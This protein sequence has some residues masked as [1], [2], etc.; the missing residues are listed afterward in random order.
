VAIGGGSGL[1]SLLRGLKNYTPNITAVVAV[2]DNGQS[3]G[4]IRKE[5]NT[6]PPGD[7]RKC[8]CALS[9][10][11]DLLVEL[12]SYRFKKGK[13][14]NGH[15]L[16]NLL[17]VALNDLEGG[18]DK[19]VIGLS[20]ILKTVGKVL[21]VTLDKVNIIG[22]MKSGA[23]V[24]GEVQISQTGHVD[25]I[26][27]ISLSANA[28]IYPPVKEAIN[29]ADIII[30]GPGSLYTSIIPPL[31]VAGLSRA[32]K[33]CNAP[34]YYICNT[35]TERGETEGY[36]VDSHLKALLKVV[37]KV[38]YCIVNNLVV[39][40]PKTPE[41][42]IGS[43]NLLLTNERKIL[44]AKIISADIIDRQNPLCHNSELLAKAILDAYNNI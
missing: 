6:L 38:D 10:D 14:L 42:E 9:P 37:K 44:G 34:I 40:I 29:N 31:A 26:E 17:M 21:P 2:T 20:E 15:S 16:G 33:N 1:S 7:I 8:I 36:D 18:F 27:S 25:P 13:G 4:I 41:G 22:H 32:L 39:K 28:H 11:E 12:L 19:A 43:I 3:S 5:F 35:S 30:I 23:V 24:E